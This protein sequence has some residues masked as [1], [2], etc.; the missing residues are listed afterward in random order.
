MRFLL[1]ALLLAGCEM[2]VGSV[3]RACTSEQMT[4]MQKYVEQCERGFNK[5]HCF[6]QAEEAYCDKKAK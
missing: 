3:P 2:R 1:F 4:L 6:T 5:G